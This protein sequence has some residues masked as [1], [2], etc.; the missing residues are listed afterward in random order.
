MMAEKKS[1]RGTT[2]REA[3]EKVREGETFV[4]N[5]PAVGQVE[6]PRPEQLAYFGGLAAL[7]ALELI[8]WPVALVIAAGHFLASNH[9]NKVLEELGEAMQDA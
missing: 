9:H 8:D 5:L 2:Q 6:I 1:R 7:A 3:V 4:V